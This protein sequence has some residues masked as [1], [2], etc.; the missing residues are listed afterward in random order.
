M[1]TKW[2]VKSANE[3]LDN[4][5]Q[6]A[7]VES[8]W[9]ISKS[10]ERGRNF[11]FIKEMHTDGNLMKWSWYKLGDLMN[12]VINNE[13]RYIDAMKCRMEE[14]INDRFIKSIDKTFARYFLEKCED[15]KYCYGLAY[16]I[17]NHNPMAYDRIIAIDE[18]NA[19][20]ERMKSYVEICEKGADMW[21]DSSKPYDNF[22]KL[23]QEEIEAVE[24]FIETLQAA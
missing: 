6:R 11:Y 16:T 4:L 19:L 7:N 22:V 8:L 23:N 14:I 12:D 13:S 9:N 5:M 21:N 10:T 1:T 17:H 18:K 2:T 24:E 15:G 3:Y 20:I